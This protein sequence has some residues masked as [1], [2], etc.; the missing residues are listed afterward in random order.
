VIRGVLF[1]LGHTL[2]VADDDVG[3]TKVGSTTH[4]LLESLRR[5]GL[6]VGVVSNGSGEEVERFALG[7]LVDTT[8]TPAAAGAGKPDARIFA[9]ALESLGLEG[10]DALF[11]G[12]R[13]HEDVR[14]AEE[15]GMTTVQALWF[16]VDEPVDG[17][18]PDFMAFTQMDVLNIIDRL[19]GE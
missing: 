14:G 1:A 6:K 16:R 13:L 8:A 15:V 10:Y 7:P 19:N 11:V 3:E 5:R 2:V 17:V 18:E 4:A 12:D 9:L